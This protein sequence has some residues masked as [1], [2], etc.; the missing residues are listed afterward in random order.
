[1]PI[2]I[3]FRQLRVFNEVAKLGSMA[4]AAD[5]L[6][7]T[8]PAVSMQVKELEAQVGLPLFD[9]VGRAVSLSTAGEY[10]L[11]YAVRLLADL[12]DAEHAMARLR[13]LE[14]GA[15]TIGIV[16]TAK[17]FVPH[18]LARFHEEHPGVEV[19]LSV[20]ADRADLVALVVAHSTL[21]RILLCVALEMPVDGYRR[22]LAQSQANLT[23][24]RYEPGATPGS[25]RLLV[26]ND[27]SHLAAAGQAP[28][29]PSPGA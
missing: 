7:L 2:N 28:W 9:R 14:Q 15:L 12:K 18:L 27:T 17:Y 22:R 24:L 11:V 26:L 20:A 19:K 1:M 5:A 23:V 21:N 3:T 13:N 25:A 6:H 10:F 29:E 4:R 8:P 16:S